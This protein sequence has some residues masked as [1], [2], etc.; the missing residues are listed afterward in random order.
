MLANFSIA[1]NLP[2]LA[3]FLLV[4][5]LAGISLFWMLRAEKSFVFETLVL[6]VNLVVLPL[7]LFVA[8][9][10]LISSIY[11]LAGLY[12]VWTIAHLLLFVRAGT[13]HRRAT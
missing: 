9:L 2:A 7:M 3:A 6:L 5:L 10:A 12:L 1:D 4:P 13:R 11:W 8:W